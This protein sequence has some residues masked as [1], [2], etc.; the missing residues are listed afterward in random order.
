MFEPISDTAPP[1]KG[2]KLLAHLQQTTDQPILVKFVAP[3]CAAC[4]TLAPVLE[5]L[6]EQ[7]QDNLHLV[8]IDITQEPELAMD[9]GVRTAPT[10]VLFAKETLRGKVDGLKPKNVY[11]DLV[12]ALL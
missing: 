11:S 12:E 10:V 6:M 4:K 5:Q 8:T 2:Q 1:M 3:H 9:L 7:H